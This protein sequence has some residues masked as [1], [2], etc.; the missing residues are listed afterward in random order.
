MRFAFIGGTPR[1]FALLR[2]LV[3]SNYLPLYNIILKEDDHEQEK[4]SSDVVGFLHKNSLEATVKRK[5]SAA[6]YQNIKE[7]K[8]DFIIVC[9][10]RSLIDTSINKFLTVG[11]LAAHDS[12]LPLYRG[13]APLNWAI[14]NGEQFTGVTLFKI[15]DGVVDSGEVYGQVK[16]KIEKSDY[17]NNV[18]NKVMHATIVLYMDFI[19]NYQNKTLSSYRQNED[20]ATYTCK[21]SPEDGRINWT[22]DSVKIYN[23]V[24]GLA[25]PFPGAFC[26]FE[27]QKVIV[28]KAEL[29]EHNEMNYVG[30]IPGRVISLK[31]GSIE[32]LCGKGSIK[33]TAW[34]L[35]GNNETSLPTEIVKSITSTLV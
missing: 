32:V 3:E 18:Y 34:Q 13:F 11:M 19:E 2:K 9:G 7:L 30:R 28:Q 23:L 25:N 29:G 24:R 1:G 27:G 22:D 15:D 16:I 21:R 5:L 14:I 8:L 20:K 26:Y 31:N 12:L 17:A 35:S 4:V 6:D 33:I 10:W